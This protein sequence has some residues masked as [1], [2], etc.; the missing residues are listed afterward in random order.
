MTV[1]IKKILYATDLS[2]N[3]AFA[4]QYAADYA[5][6]H[7]AKIVILHVF[8]DLRQV[9]TTF[10]HYFTGDQLE[11]LSKNKDRTVEKIRQRLGTFCENVRQDDPSC[12]FRVDQIEI[13]EGYPANVI[14]DKADEFG[15]DVIF[16]GTHGKG[17]VA[18]AFLG[19]VAQKV[20]R[21]S[22]KPV[23]TIPLPDMDD[24]SAFSH[25]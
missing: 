8:E 20:L 24:N 3:S 14:L 23:F 18:N 21:R 22:R 19:S 4:F 2:P 7:D 17:F 25:F 15:C 5:D 9:D 10:K 16:M 12:V 1:A 13:S 6:K 11:A